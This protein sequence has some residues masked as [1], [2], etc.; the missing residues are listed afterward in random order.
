MQNTSRK[1]SVLAASTGIL[2]VPSLKCCDSG[3][4]LGTV[5]VFFCIGYEK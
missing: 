4:S 2:F 5:G 1:F 3:R